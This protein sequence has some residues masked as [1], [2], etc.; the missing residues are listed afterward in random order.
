[1]YPPRG[2]N[3][4]EGIC[5]ILTPSGFKSIKN[6]K[7]GDLVISGSG[8]ERIVN[9]VHKNQYSGYI[10]TLII[11]G[12]RSVK[13]TNEHPFKTKKGWVVAGDLYS[14]DKVISLDGENEITKCFLDVKDGINV[15]NLT[16]DIDA[17]YVT[18]IGI[19]HNCGCRVHALTAAYVKENGILVLDGS[20]FNVVNEPGWDLSP[21]ELW[22]NPR[23]DKYHPSIGN[24]LKKILGGL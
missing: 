9:A 23:F 4:F 16:V 18:E 19:V 1:M 10:K 2:F 24:S 13:V 8:E 22:K 11:K 6:I 20:T 3:C 21:D 14:G 12:N 15:Y 17:T 5:K 7:Q